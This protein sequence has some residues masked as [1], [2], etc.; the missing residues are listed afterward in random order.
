[1]L[2]EYVGYH[3]TDYI[4]YGGQRLCQLRELCT[5]LH[6]NSKIQQV[7]AFSFWPLKGSMPPP[8]PAETEA[9]KCE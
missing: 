1:M 4:E 9:H 2:F 7:F 6:P 3:T 5:I 8:P